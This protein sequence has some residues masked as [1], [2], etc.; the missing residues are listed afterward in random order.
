MRQ[1]NQVEL[2]LGTGRNG[3][4]PSTAVQE[5]EARA[6]KTDIES[7]AA[8]VGPSMEAIV[9]RLNLKK[10]LARV[11]RNKDAPGIDGPSVAD[12]ASYLKEH[13]Q[14]LEGTY[15]PQPVRRVEIP[16]ATGGTRPLGIPTV[17]D[18]LIQQ[19]VMQVLRADWDGT[20][21]EASF[22]FRPGRSAHQAV[23][24]AQELIASGHDHVVDIDHTR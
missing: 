19:A 2:N 13:A 11:K 15:K 20:F 9:E 10:A 8:L 18:R 7:R 14:L 3:E 16:K 24:R 23:A 5:T 22:G 1:K 12:L 4:A 6:A 17:L 21:S